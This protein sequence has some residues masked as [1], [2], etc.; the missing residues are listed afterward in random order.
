MILRGSEV[1]AGMRSEIR[2]ALACLAGP[3]P[4]LVILRAGENPGDRAYERGAARTLEG[5]GMRLHTAALPGDADTGAFLAALHSIHAD[6]DTDGVLVMRPLPAHIDDAAVRAA[7]DPERDVDGIAPINV[8]RV[9]MGEDGFCPCTP[10]AVMAILRHAAVPL[11]GRRAVV[12]GRSLVVGRPLAMLLLRENATVTVCHTHT[13]DLADIC[14]AGDIVVAAAGSPGLIGADHISP[15]AAVVDVGIRADAS[16]R[17]LGDVDFEA[18]R[19]RCAL[20]TPVP[21]GVGAVTTS[22]LARHLVQAA[23]RRRGERP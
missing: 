13:R 21:G 17:L 8:A 2:E 9:F 5:L 15:G 14:R 23:A 4:R 1:A 22:V 11:A 20:I 3:A 18:V 10:E 12:V 19:G 7:M 16:G 6:P